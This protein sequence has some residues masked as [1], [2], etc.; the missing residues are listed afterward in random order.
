M[1]I[2]IITSNENENKINSIF[3]DQ[4]IF[5]NINNYKFDSKLGEGRFG[6]V[7]LAI[8]KLTDQ[9][10]AIKVIDKNQIKLNEH[11]QRVD[12][13][14]SILKQVNHYNI[15]K[16]FSCIENEE[17]IYLVQEYVNGNDLNLFIKTKEKPKI[18]EQKILRYFR[19]IIS[20]IEY[21]H[22]LGI[23]HRD[24]KPENILIN[25]KN[26]IKLIDFGLGKIFSK[27][28]LLKTQ[29][30]SPFYASPEMINGNKYNG[31]KSDIW[32]LGVILYLML[33]EELPFMDAEVK[34]LYKKILEG[35]YEI[36]EDKITDVSKEAIDLVK[37]IL[38]VNPKKRIKISGIK[39]HPW[40]TQ[41][42][43]VLYEGI[44]VKETIMPIDE[45]IVEEIYKNY[46]YD[47][48]RIRNSVIR[49][50]YNNIRSLYFFLLEK[51]IREGNES[52][53]D[54]FSKLYLN[55]INDEKNKLANY[56]NNIENALKERMNSHEKL[57]AIPDYEENKELENNQNKHIF[58]ERRGRKVKTQILDIN[59]ICNNEADSKLKNAI[60][61]IKT[62]K[63]K[64]KNKRNTSN[65]LIQYDNNSHNSKL[66]SFTKMKTNDFYNLK[67]YR[68]K[69]SERI[70][71]EINKSIN[72]K[73]NKNEIFS[74]SCREKSEN[75]RLG[76]SLNK[77]NDNFK[78]IIATYQKNILTNHNTKSNHNKSSNVNSQRKIIM[79]KSRTNKKYISNNMKS[80]N[81]SLFASCDKSMPIDKKTIGH[82]LYKNNENDNNENKGCFNTN[83][84]S[85]VKI[86]LNNKYAPSKNISNINKRYIKEKIISSPMKSIDISETKQKILSSFLGNTRSP[87][88]KNRFYI[89]KK[90]SVPSLPYETPDKSKMAQGKTMSNFNKIKNKFNNKYESTKISSKNIKSN[91]RKEKNIKIETKTISNMKMKKTQKFINYKTNSIL[92]NQKQRNRLSSIH[93]KIKY[94]DSEKSDNTNVSNNITNMNNFNSVINENNKINKANKVKNENIIIP[95][96]N[97]NPYS[98]MNNFS[99]LKKENN[100]LIITNFSSKE[101]NNSQGKKILVLMPKKENLKL[102]AQKILLSSIKKPENKKKFLFENKIDV[103][104]E[105]K[106]VNY[107]YPFDLNCLILNKNNIKI[108]ETFEKCLNNKKISFNYVKDKI[109]NKNQISFNCIKKN[110]I[111]FRVKLSKIQK[112]YNSERN[113]LYICKI[114][115]LSDAKYDFFGL[116]NSFSL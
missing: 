101:R 60:I 66:D 86:N 40:F 63:K 105:K 72:N 20:A 14:I 76:S 94:L 111:K 70:N 61:K 37:K 58:R 49:N 43:D 44:N 31:I 32:S 69:L 90:I 50:L 113:N 71:M 19:Q 91:N 103:E 87:M 57:D 100:S 24:L 74:D 109:G 12:S 55:Y 53:S 2:S 110:G 108:K 77:K 56:D 11:R 29:C 34:R 25:E 62:N 99:L 85:L 96:K 89:N 98:T 39:N 78:T 33:F 92:L 10:A 75:Q 106:I 51:K 88:I 104:S 114:K 45:E 17:R 22:K 68:Q 67:E 82:I 1:S 48:M 38:E 59:D 52:V 35:K 7:R 21:I 64:E 107:E 18:R 5:D 4:T 54:L 115:K 36:P 3:K 8:H 23:A 79:N 27:G 80:K 116:I 41:I 83:R 13:E 26:D 102:K 95:K 28:E 46:G 84:S 81:S 47:K 15:S 30:G 93:K 97:I 112:E 16:L 42:S 65:F 9:K 6:K 73:N